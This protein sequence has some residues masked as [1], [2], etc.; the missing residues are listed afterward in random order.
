MVLLM[1]SIFCCLFA[2]RIPWLGV[3]LLCVTIILPTVLAIAKRKKIL[4]FKF[5]TVLF[6]TSL[7]I[8]STILFF[9]NV[10]TWTPSEIISGN[11]Y[12]IEGTVDDCYDSDDV[13]VVVLKDLKIGIK[14]VKGKMTLSV[15]NGGEFDDS[16]IGHR[17]SC[18]C[19]V[20]KN[21]LIVDNKVND[22]AL[23]ND[24]RY[25][26]SINFKY[27]SKTICSPDLISKIDI[28]IKH[29]LID[30]MGT[31]NGL[32]AY[33]MLTGNKSGIPDDIAD[34]FSVAGVAHILAV[35]GLHIGFLMTIVMF[36]LR[37]LKV[38]RLPS[39]LIGAVIMFAYALLAG[40]SPSVTRA[41]IMCVVGSG[42]VLFG[43]QQD[44][45][46]SLGFASTIMLTFS[47]LLLFNIGFIMSVGAVFAIVNF[48]PVFTRGLT[49]IGLNEKLCNAISVSAAAQLGIFPAV[50]WAFG[51]LQTYSLLIN[52]VLMPL[53]SAAFMLTFVTLILSIIIPPLGFTLILSGGIIKVLIVAATFCATLPYAQIGITS[54]IIVMFLYPFYFAIGD[55]FNC[56]HKRALV[57]VG[58]TLAA[59]TIIFLIVV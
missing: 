1:L 47:P 59:L 56:K 35:S 3:L 44:P 16:C 15:Y 26:A 30:A 12:A 51:A 45:F 32:V 43:E 36:L 53:M 5:V 22:M 14:A 31:E 49:K 25:S 23:N 54:S 42:A 21:N 11:K 19:I 17:L 46:N 40:F 29:K 27:I 2:L 48:T 41:A 18:E 52:I 50:V 8:I 58:G 13:K 37:K 34:A 9:V 7:C 33:G 38:R 10:Y 57:G 28:F 20:Y 4:E 39:F 24:I 55:F 6:T